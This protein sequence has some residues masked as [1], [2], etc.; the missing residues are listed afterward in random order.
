M[1]RGNDN[2]LTATSFKT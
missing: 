2:V 1:K